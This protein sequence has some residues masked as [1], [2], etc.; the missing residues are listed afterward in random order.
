VRVA[1]ETVGN[2]MP[3]GMVWA[4]AA[5]P[6]LLARHADLS[7]ATSLAGMAGRKYL[8]ALSQAA[9]LVVG[10]LA[11]K[12][13]LEAG[14]ARSL[15]MPGLAKT[16][17][18]FAILLV[19]VAEG[20]ASGLGAGRLIARTCS[21]LA[22]IPWTALRGVLG[23]IDHG[24]R[25]TDRAMVALFANRHRKMLQLSLVN[26]VGWLFEALETWVILRALGSHVGLGDAIGIETLV[27]LLRQ[28][29]V[30][31]PA[32]LGALEMGY[33]AFLTGTG[34]SLDLCAA[35]V[36]LKRLREL[37]WLGVGGAL[38][39]LERRPGRLIVRSFEPASPFTQR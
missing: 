29:L 8:L 1:T 6:T 26:V 36:L 20:V 35:F 18:V 27:V 7:P 17:L 10:Y 22:R 4:E 14:F 33:A 24:A 37:A 31:L 9:Y 12:N 39:V 5:K 38:L 3:L 30:F 34:G 28:V 32:G 19:L 21:L 11:G 15:G 16:A 13:A 2:A 23:G 25:S